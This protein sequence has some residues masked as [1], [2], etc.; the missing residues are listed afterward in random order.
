MVWVGELILGKLAQ[1]PNSQPPS[2]H[3]TSHDR[4]SA[5]QFSPGVGQ[6]SKHFFRMTS[7]PIVVYIL[8]GF[9][10]GLRLGKPTGDKS[11]Q[12]FCFGKHLPGSGTDRKYAMKRRPWKPAESLCWAVQT[13]KLES[14][15]L[16][17]LN[18][19]IVCLPDELPY[20]NSLKLNH[21]SGS[22]K[23][24]HIIILFDASAKSRRSDWYIRFVK[25]G[26]I[27]P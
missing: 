13:G 2:H 11:I 17:I 27:H 25:T 12:I 14:F 3:R 8:K 19:H 6:T 24:Y 4:M 21:T 5:I 26:W 16:H 10:C 22:I 15:S 9:L 23:G 7:H 18:L 20:L 1:L